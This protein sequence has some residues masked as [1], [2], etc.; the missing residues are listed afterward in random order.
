MQAV[1]S[2]VTM[3]SNAAKVGI[4]PV[5]PWWLLASIIQWQA[6]LQEYDQERKLNENFNNFVQNFQLAYWG[7]NDAEEQI[8]SPY[9]NTSESYTEWLCEFNRVCCIS[10]A[11]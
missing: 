6:Y 1:N 5:P 8:G 7:P 2:K 4:Y 3:Q 10:R 11:V 9:N